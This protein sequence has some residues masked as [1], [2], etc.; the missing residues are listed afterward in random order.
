MATP[1]KKSEKQDTAKTEVTPPRAPPA[2]EHSA[3]AGELEELRAENE[4]LKQE[5]KAFEVAARAAVEKLDADDK[6]AKTDKSA[7]PPPGFF[8]NG[9]GQLVEEKYRGPKQYE[10]GE[11]LFVEGA[12]RRPGDRFT[13]I[14][15]QPGRAWVPLV[16][17][18]EPELVRAEP[19]N[20]PNTQSL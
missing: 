10:A 9:K 13:A 1:E 14:D 18:T 17:K 11:H 12:F 5:R 16:P 15:T 3:T 20:S 6:A 4:R 19:A 8:R 7:T 2:A